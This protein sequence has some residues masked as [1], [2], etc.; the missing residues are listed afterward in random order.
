VLGARAVTL[1]AA[2]PGAL[3]RRRSV[4]LALAALPPLRSHWLAVVGKPQS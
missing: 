1:N 4:A 2:L 3:R